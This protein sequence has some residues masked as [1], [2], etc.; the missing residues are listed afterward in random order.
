MYGINQ[1]IPTPCGGKYQPMS[2]GKGDMK[3]GC[4]KKRKKSKRK[5]KKEERSRE[6]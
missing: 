2:F 3:R 5:C 4:E 1:K 6:L